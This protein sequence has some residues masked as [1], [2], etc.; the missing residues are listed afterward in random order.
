MRHGGLDNR[1]KFD[2]YELL[3]CWTS[4]SKNY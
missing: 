4:N 2:L 1:L 3:V